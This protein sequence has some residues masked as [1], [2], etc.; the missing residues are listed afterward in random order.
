[1][2]TDIQALQDIPDGKPVR[3]FL[4][5]TKQDEMV[6][7]Q[8]V[9]QKTAAPKFELLF[10]PGELPVDVLD[11]KRPCIVSIDMGGP[12]VSLE[13]MIR[14]VASAQKLEMVARKTVNHRQLREYFRV[15][16]ETKVVTRAF[17]KKHAGGVKTPW[18][19]EG[20]TVDISG[21]G[22][23]ALFTESPPA[24]FPV[25]LEISLPTPKPSFVKVLAHQ[26]RS[27]QLGDGTYEVAYHYDEIRTEDRDRIIGCCLDIQR[28]MLRLRVQV[29]D[30]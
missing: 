15:D 21:S 8:C 24:E 23:R 19:Y 6:K 3:I 2:T 25:R 13:A 12:T 7:A 9:Y 20:R 10:A 22:V 18:E 11:S 14:E 27:R 17:V 28:Q 1:M 30:D 16:A 4:P 29:K 5:V 26:V